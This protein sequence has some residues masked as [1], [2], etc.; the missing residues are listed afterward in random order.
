MAY[1]KS[2]VSFVDAQTIQI[3]LELGEIIDAAQ[4]TE[5]PAGAVVL[6]GGWVHDASGRDIGK[7]WGDNKFFFG[8][9]TYN[10]SPIA[11]LFDTKVINGVAQAPADTVSSWQVQ[12]GGQTVTVEAVSR[13]TNVLDSAQVG[14]YND[15]AFKTVEN[16]FLRLAT[17]MTEGSA[18]SISFA[19]ADFT[20][21]TAVYNP[22][23]VV[24]EAIHVNLKGF[25]PDDA[26]KVAFLS[27][28]NGWDVDTTSPDGGAGVAQEF[29]PG[30]DW[31]IINQA[32]GQ[33]VLSGEIELTN[34]K[35][36]AQNFWLNFQKTDTF[37]IDF[38][39]LK[40]AGTYHIEVDG[41][42]RSNS[43]EVAETHWGD[44]FELAMSGFYHQR[45]G[46]PL[47]QPYTTW[48]RPSSL[49]PDD[50]LVV[51]QSRLKITDTSE[52]YK[53]GV[54]HGVGLDPQ[55]D[56]GVVVENAQGGWHDAGDWDRRTQHLEAARK[57][58]EGFENA[59][60][61]HES[62]ILNI[63]E[64]TNDIPD[65]L[66]EAIYGASVFRRLQAADGGVSGGIE[67]T[68]SPRLG[69]GSW[70]DTNRV[71][72]YAK[73][74]WTTWEYAATAAKISFA[75]KAYNVAESAAWQESA[76]RAMNWAEAQN[77][78]T[79]STT[80]LS[81]NIAAAELYRLT[82]NETFHDIYKETT[83]YD[84]PSWQ[85]AWN[86][87]QL[88]SAF[89]YARTNQPGVDAAIKASG[90]EDILR[91]ADYINNN[92]GDRGAFGSTVNPN[93]KTGWGSNEVAMDEAADLYVRA[94]VLTGDDKWLTEIQSEAQYL[95]GANPLNM[96]YLTGLEGRNPENFLNIDAETLG[97]NGPDGITLYGEHNIFDYGTTWFHDQ[98]S[99][100]VWP[101]FWQTPV[102]ESYNG[103]T[104]FVPLTEY[105][106][107]QGM[108]DTA[109]VTGYLAAQSENDDAVWIAAG[110]SV[111]NGTEG[112]DFLRG[113]TGNDK[114]NGG[115]G[116]D[117][118]DGGAG[119]DQIT[120]SRGDDSLSG[121][122]GNDRLTGGA[123]SDRINGGAGND[124]ITGDVGDDFLIGGSGAD[125]LSGG[126]GKDSLLG[127]D[128][129]D[130][131]A[132]NEDDDI[133]LGGGDADRL[134]G[135]TGNDTLHG[136]TG[137]DV[138]SGGLGNDALN[139][140]EGND[141]LR[142]DDGNDTLLGLADADSLYGGNGNDRLDGGAGADALWGG[143]GIDTFVFGLGSD[144]ERLADF[145]IGVDKIELDDALWTGS[146]SA[147]QVLAEFGTLAAN[148]RSATLDFHD[149]DILVIQSATTFTLAQLAAD[150]Q[151]G[152]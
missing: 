152:F 47:E 11:D 45:S 141:I 147:A 28:W 129:A 76:I 130:N 32:T 27:S 96:T 88:E 74:V 19:D 13:K 80:L 7:S 86:E 24:S 57:M 145:Q 5:F 133:L 82:G 41:V 22:E 119:N 103:F 99:G 23:T 128:G 4:T 104:L 93:G 132:G 56:T 122:A 48:E 55:Y 84:K 121:G 137:A 144:R 148:G 106:V 139:G 69:D 54:S 115:F 38:S 67:S 14:P 85:V 89:V 12:V 35:N 36:D 34:A 77:E 37:S 95:M 110:Q 62:V 2:T 68:G 64:A 94:H 17:P 78:P 113:R 52:G 49:D 149:G 150:L 60:E 120:G 90:V 118:I 143:A 146:L 58:I 65:V 83:V 63:P 92:F 46:I 140:D 131:L 100:T 101:N 61:F 114:L 107:Q 112:A 91:E 87:R 136:G 10:A 81:R 40:T 79:D 97:V 33:V 135:F 124:S 142:G 72:A 111:L 29:A 73:D 51:T 70:H 116:D 109:Y 20:T 21:L 102:A 59:P 66:D 39:S 50:G 53:G 98:V 31:R 6:P 105:T 127:G 1:T 25:D 18:L 8:F 3:R 134:S 151:I 30:T 138:L 71:F 42:G 75:L 125:T 16:V 26:Y 108:T 123:G 43:F 117:K 44:T 15:Y 126:T 9:D